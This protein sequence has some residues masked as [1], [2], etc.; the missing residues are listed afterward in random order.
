MSNSLLNIGAS[1]LRVA[2]LALQVTGHNI[3]NASTPGYTRQQA[4]QTSN[5]PLYVGAGYM[6]Q[7]AHVTTVRRI[8]DNYLTSQVTANQSQ[9][10]GLE[11]QS[12]LLGTLDGIL[13]NSNTGL[14]VAL[15][16]FFAALDGVAANSSQS[17]PR[18]AFIAAGEALANRIRSV[19]QRLAAQATEVNQEI[20]A[21]VTAAN[22]ASKQIAALNERIRLAEAVRNGQPA[23]DLRDQRDTLVRELNTIVRTRV[24]EDSEGQFDLYIGNG[25]PLVLGQKAFALKADASEFD[26]SQYSV[27][28]DTG[29][30]TVPLRVEQLGGGKLAGLMAF[31]HDTL[32]PARAQLG[33]IVAA[34]GTAMNAQHA[35]GYDLDGGTGT[36]LF[37]F[38][39]MGSAVASARN[40]GAGAVSATLLDVNQL[41]GHDYQLTFRGGEWVAQRLPN[42]DTVGTVTPPGVLTVDGLEFTMGG[43]PDEGDTFLLRPASDVARSF[44]MVLNDPRKF[45]AAAMDPTAAGGGALDNGNANL[46]VA[47]RTAGLLNGGATSLGNAY[48]DLVTDVGTQA[49]GVELMAQAQSQVLTD[50]VAAQQA[51]SG[52]NLDEEAANLL[53]YQQ[54]YQAS[55]K[56][57]QTAVTVFDTL[58]SIANR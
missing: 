28:F 29:N 46:L 54:A 3:A 49:R 33:R 45:A 56:V 18:Q 16:D 4:L 39:G 1:G 44:E 50:S 9:A 35:A 2:E 43:T 51:V 24:V 7:G 27:S 47:L 15:Q 48:I 36:A 52:V 30:G 34:L 6:G 37:S 25:Q 57:M 11:R 14:T 22:V 53:R 31:R 10:S 55:A 8:F 19:D 58:L 41:S 26:A 20:P 32:E 42:N 38:A 13:S 23:N 21:Q 12:Q 40:T 17:A 5:L